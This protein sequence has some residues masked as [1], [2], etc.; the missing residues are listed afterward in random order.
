[1]THPVIL[2]S[3]YS[4]R[5]STEEVVDWVDDG[6]K[7]IN[8][9]Y[10]NKVISK[11]GLIFKCKINSMQSHF[12]VK[13]RTYRD[14]GKVFAGRWGPP[15]GSIERSD[16]VEC[17]LRSLQLAAA[18][19]VTEELDLCPFDE[20]ILDGMVPQLVRIHG[21]EWAAIFV[22]EYLGQNLKLDGA[23]VVDG[24][25]FNRSNLRSCTKLY[26]DYLACGW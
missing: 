14:S 10:Q 8:L 22:L 5:Q 15:K 4:R 20:P 19:E 24:G 6:V 21:G 12:L 17:P 9:K 16:I 1:M 7:S 3:L 13:G 11:V 18:R 2:V 23:E 26:T 25:W